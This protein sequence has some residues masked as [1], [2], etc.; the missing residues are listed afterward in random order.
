MITE[1]QYLDALKVVRGYLKQIEAEVSDKNR[2]YSDILDRELQNFDFS[3]RLLNCM[4][5]HD[6]S[7]VRD[8][9]SI[10]DGNDLFKLRNFGMRTFNELDLFMRKHHLQFGMLNY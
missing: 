2:T 7:T 10:Q 9:V 6:I 4:K 8:L 3:V 5:P 1:G